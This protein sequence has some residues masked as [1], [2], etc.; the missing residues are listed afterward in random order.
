[1]LEENYLQLSGVQHFAFCR[2]QW[3]IIHVE[4]QWEDNL[5]TVLGTIVHTK[6]HDASFHEK[7]KGVLIYRGMHVQSKELGTVGMLD[8]VKFHSSKDGVPLIGRDG[9]W[10][11]YPIEY[12][13]GDPKEN[14]ADRIQLC[15]EA[16]CLEEMFFC[17]IPEGSLY[18]AHPHRRQ[19]VLLDDDLRA[20]TKKSFQEM[21]SMIQRGYTPR[22]KPQKHCNACSL[23]ERCLPRIYKN[24]DVASYYEQKLREV[25]S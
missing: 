3:A 1:M 20:L 10:L 7:R 16:I 13:K 25:D 23:K 9:L 11:P 18:Y 12:K 21:H 4:G 22:V 5:R 6:V 19:R 15:A 2:R 14:P 8:E 24:R 17:N